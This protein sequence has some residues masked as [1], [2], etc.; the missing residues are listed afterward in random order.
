LFASL[1][2]RCAVILQDAQGKSEIHVTY[3]VAQRSAANP[4]RPE[5]QNGAPKRAKHVL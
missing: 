1:L 5:K 2:P 3:K 4:C